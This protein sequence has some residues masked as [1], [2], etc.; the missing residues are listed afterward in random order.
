MTDATAPAAPRSRVRNAVLA[1]FLKNRVAT[2]SAVLLILF[3]IVVVF[4]EF[5]APYDYREAD[6][7][8]ATAPPQTLRFWSEE[9]GFSLRPHVCGL[10]SRRDM[11]TLALVYE[12]DCSDRLPL[13]FFVRGEPYEAWFGRSD[14]H[15]FGFEGGRGHLLGADFRGRDM[16]SGILI[17]A[18]VPLSL[19]VLGVALTVVI[20]AVL[21][22]ISGYYGGRTDTLI[23]RTAETFRLFPPLPLFLALAAALPP[24]LPGGMV[25]GGMM[26][27]YAVV[28]W[29]PLCREVRGMVLVLRESEYVLAAQAFGASGARVI[30]RHLVPNV[31]SHLLVT[32]TLGIPI[33]IIFE[34]TISFLGLG[35]RPPMTSW[36]L[37][38]Q[39]AQ[40]LDVIALYPWML[41]PS[42][43]IMA[44]VLLFNFVGD[45]VR[46][47][48]DPRG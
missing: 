30:L 17:G 23:Q 42:L 5:F 43:F 26:V 46:D 48:V 38:L 2:V 11:Q 14:L 39:Q 3:G 36:G 22:A 28:Q 47:A 44:A 12:E 19:G 9:A 15:F 24:V 8:Y 27:I 1:R 35:I 10:S 6:S 29:P 25:F 18:R 20:G 13:R 45:G 33:V 7:R 37:Q 31:S 32:A 34:S 21:G 40:R 41:S 4:A 16:L